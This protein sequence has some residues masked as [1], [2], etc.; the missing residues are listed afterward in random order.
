MVRP[1][2]LVITQGENAR[3]TCHVPRT[4]DFF[5]GCSRVTCRPRESGDPW[6]RLWN[7][8]PQHKRVYARLRRAMRGDDGGERE[9]N[10]PEV[11]ITQRANVSCNILDGPDRHENAADDRGFLC[12]FKPRRFDLLFRPHAVHA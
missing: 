1:A 12:P 5:M 6:Y 4:N 11:L 3:L 7:M 10:Q 8:G 2:P 9:P